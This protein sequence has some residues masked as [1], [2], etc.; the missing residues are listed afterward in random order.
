MRRSLVS[1]GWR[2]ARLLARARRG[3]LTVDMALRAGVVLVAVLASDSVTLAA[4]PRG[5]AQPSSSLATPEPQRHRLTRS[6]ANDCSDLP[7]PP[8]G[9][10]GLR[11]Y[12]RLSIQH[13]GV[14]E[15]TAAQLPFAN[16]PGYIYRQV[17]ER[18]EPNELD[19][20]LLRAPIPVTGGFVYILTFGGGEDRCGAWSLDVT[21][22]E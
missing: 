17:A 10:P 6:G 5:D 8:T 14:L 15:V 18:W 9:V 11:E 12:A 4:Q 22:P 19:Y 20:I 7:A 3:R 16:N 2:A 21:Y 1:Y 13:D